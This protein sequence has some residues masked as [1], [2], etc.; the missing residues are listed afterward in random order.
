MALAAAVGGALCAGEV[1]ARPHPRAAAALTFPP[2]AGDAFVVRDGGVDVTSRGYAAARGFPEPLRLV[3]RALAGD[4]WVRAPVAYGTVAL[5]A[6]RG[7]V[8]F[9]A[10]RTGPVEAVHRVRLPNGKPLA[11]V[12]R[13]KHLFFMT[14]SNLTGLLVADVSD[15]SSPRVVAAEPNPT[16]AWAT[17]MAMVGDAVYATAS[18]ILL[19]WDV[20]DPLRPKALRTQ[21]LGGRALAARGTTLY[22]VKGANELGSL[23]VADPR[24]TRAGGAVTLGAA[25]RIEA[26]RFLGDAML[27]PARLSPKALAL[28][29]KQSSG[30]RS[31]PLDLKEGLGPDAPTRLIPA[32]YV[33]R[34][35][36]GEQ[37]QPVACWVGGPLAATGRVGDRAVAL[38]R[39][40]RGGLAFVDASD[41][42]A[43]RVL[44]IRGALKGSAALDGNR[45]YVARRNPWRQDGGLFVYELSEPGKP[46]LLGKLIAGDRR[47][48]EERSE[49]RVADVAGRYVTIADPAFGFLVVDVGE[50]SN[51]RIAGALHEAG[52]WLS[53]AVTDERIFLAGDPGGLAILDH[54]SPQTARR[55]GSFMV[56]PGWGVAGRGTV[57][58]V[59]N[60]SGLRI[61]E[62]AE[63]EQPVELAS[64]GG[65]AGARIVKLHGDLAFVLGKR[66]GAILDV[67]DPTHPRRLAT[68][69][70][71]EP[72]D[73]AVAG[74]W[75]YVTERQ[76]LSATPLR[77]PGRRPPAR[78]GR[79]KIVNTGEA[80]HSVAVRGAHLFAGTADGL[81]VAR[82]REPGDPS[83]SATRKGR[84]GLLVGDYL[85][86]CA[87]YGEHNLFVTDVG[88]P[89]APRPIARY[90]PGRHSYA[91][92]IA[93]RRG[94]VYLTSLPYLSI[95]SAP[96]S[97]QAPTGPATVAAAVKD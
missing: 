23:D 54:R 36:E 77:V 39:A 46:R 83:F 27:V 67:R 25:E 29:E 41:P 91:T 87:Y 18:G 93:V 58:F 19:A 71:E 37:P 72:T 82:L 32:V 49:W 11:A 81:A 63:P 69:D 55:V 62:T 53:S 73:M 35:K 3:R 22:F 33:L 88:N 60:A 57:A 70:V 79:R 50:P 76:G 15:P 31:A 96:V 28:Q 85:Y 95:L 8:R 40:S 65:I 2:L 17:S 78:D 97:P 75:L 9:F 89:R 7:R 59:A 90:R 20:T 44:A 4:D 12:R 21:R 5:D 61:V 84:G 6:A 30:W 94:L 80:F 45:L 48:M 86:G 34:L 13:G 42:T 68:L 47:W 1:A 74:N 16:G 64:V 52:R 14:D 24:R 10:G 43:P 56:G 26:P 92:D 66:R 38:V 51:P